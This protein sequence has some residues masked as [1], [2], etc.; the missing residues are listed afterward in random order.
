MAGFVFADWAAFQA[1]SADM[2]VP[3]KMD[4]AS[5]AAMLQACL[6]QLEMLE[7]FSHEAQHEACKVLTEQLNLK[8]SQVFGALRAAVTAQQVSPPTFETM[9]ILGK[10]ES[11]RRIRL[12]IQRL[13]QSET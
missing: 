4:A 9:E 3:K 1:P 8:N 5:T 6:D 13:Q 10:T 2:L 7:D 12:A 11:L